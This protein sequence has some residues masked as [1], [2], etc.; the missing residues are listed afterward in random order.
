MTRLD[1]A[2]GGWIVALALVINTSAQAFVFAVLPT[3]G[4][5]I[6]L[7][8]LQTG[9]VLGVGALLG[10]LVAP[11]WG[12]ASERFGR[13]PI[14][15][16]TMA[17]V[18]ISPIL[19]ATALGV[20]AEI[21]PLMFT[22]AFLIGARCIQAGF[23]AGL[24]PTAQA[25]FADVTTPGK[26][27]AGMGLMS[28]ALSLGTVAGSALVWAFSGFGTFY[29][30][31]TLSVLATVTLC[32]AIMRLPE[33][34]RPETVARDA[35]KIPFK[36]V[37]P[38]FVITT[39]GM[40][41]L[42]MVQPITGLRLMDQFGLSNAGAI[43]QAG[44]V[45]TGTS[46]AMLFSQSVLAVRLGWPPHRMLAAGAI[47]GFVGIVALAFTGEYA[48]MVGAMIILGGAIGFLLP[49]NLA[50]MSLA[51]GVKAQGKVAGINTLAMGVGLVIGPTAGT[52]IYHAS[53]VAPYW[54]ATLV[55]AVL[56][57]VVFFVARPKPEAAAA[58]H[59]PAE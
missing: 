21:L 6:G 35:H 45:L 59:I 48:V 39:L 52:A 51:T 29:G 3:V 7:S 43:G 53:P 56:A 24:I 2:P 19:W 28:G 31:V 16:T 58:V 13:R 8:E 50:A 20:T 42:G 37:W 32:F 22:F 15:L 49:G 40:T 12:F 5:G 33:P 14:L 57:A 44:A 38:Y 9:G 10:M 54:T 18:V 23:G 25:Y 55:L 47:A 36:T 41:A 1:G 34:T 30:F 4:R 11:G 46:L 27:T 17:G 26:R